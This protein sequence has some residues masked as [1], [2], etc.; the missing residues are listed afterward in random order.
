[1]AVELKSEEGQSI[2]EFI[3]LLPLM[4]G[5]TLM[6]LKINMAIQVSIGN[7]KYSRMQAHHL[8]FNSPY[9]PQTSASSQGNRRAPGMHRLVVGVGEDAVTGA[10]SRPKAVEVFVARNRQIASKS[11]DLGSAEPDSRANVRVRTTVALCTFS[12]RLGSGKPSTVSS[13]WVALDGSAN[14]NPD[15]GKVFKFCDGGSRGDQR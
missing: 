13:E 8:T 2:V 5:I 4:I 7:Q 14:G 9:Y 6:M 15:Q 3:L 11:S 10:K 1:M 12:N